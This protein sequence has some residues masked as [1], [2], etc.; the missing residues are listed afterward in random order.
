MI[1]SFRTDAS[2]QIG[3]GHVM[4]CLA[5]ADGLRERGGRSIFICRL[6]AGHLLD[7]IIQRG[8]TA[9]AL[10]PAENLLTSPDHLQHADWLGT[11]WDFDSSQ[12]RKALG[13]LVVDWL[14]VDHYALDRRWEVAM[15]PFT[16]RI[17]AIDDLADRPH[18]CDLLLDQNLGRHEE[19]YRSLLINN[20]KILIGP[21]YALL[22]TEFAKWRKHS[23]QR[24]VNP[25]L[26]K[27]LI[28]MGGVD[29]TNAT[30][31]VLAA[32][33][34]CELPANLR[35]TV[36]M[37][38][39]APWLTQVRSQASTMHRPTEVVAG[40][41][42]MAQLMAESDFCIGAAGVSAWERCALGLPSFV[43]V[44]AANQRSG[45]LALQA[46]GAATIVNDTQHLM[47]QISELFSNIKASEVLRKMSQTAAQLTS[48]NGVSQIVELLFGTND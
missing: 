20:K 46:N 17:L 34:L 26:N 5:L 6:H 24:R 15:R 36:V 12:T 31:Q 48:G 23:L 19:D 10:A 42:N 40:A 22:R 33:K 7:L 37:G 9:L 30:S 44:L 3:T 32:L 43:M 18:D 2:L 13:N 27:L 39:T 38:Q 29:Q 47:T 8:H 41:C 28:T 11:S 35:I 4:R 14:I 45:A 21:Q 25:Q 16:Q 1:V